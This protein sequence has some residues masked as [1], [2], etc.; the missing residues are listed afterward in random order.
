MNEAPHWPSAEEGLDVVLELLGQA[1][2][3]VVAIDLPPKPQKGFTLSDGVNFQGV[4]RH[5]Y[6]HEGPELNPLVAFGP[7]GGFEGVVVGCLN[8]S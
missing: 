7:N 4:S 8:W 2:Q 5:A 6:C 1:T 3:G